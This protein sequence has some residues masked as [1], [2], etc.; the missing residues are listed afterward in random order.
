M[1]S[2]I[3]TES[4]E[5]GGVACLGILYQLGKGNNFNERLR[6]LRIAKP[7]FIVWGR[8]QRQANQFLL[9]SLGQIGNNITIGCTERS[10]K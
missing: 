6:I 10:G 5:E 8:L 7:P 3:K 1:D 2:A 4:S 9:K